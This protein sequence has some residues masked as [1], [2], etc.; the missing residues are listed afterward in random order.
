MRKSK[1]SQK[2]SILIK[3]IYNFL[4]YLFYP[5]IFAKK[6]IFDKEKIGILLFNPFYVFYKFHQSRHLRHLNNSSRGSFM[7]MG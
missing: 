6:W 4:Y 3:T 5:V 1:Q 7:I 2:K